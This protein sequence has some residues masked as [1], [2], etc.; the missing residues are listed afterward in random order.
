[1]KSKEILRKSK[2]TGASAL[3][4]FLALS[5]I[6]GC[7]CGG[8][9]GGSSSSSSSMDDSSSSI[10]SSSTIETPIGPCTVWG[11]PATEK[12]MQKDCFGQKNFIKLLTINKNLC[13]MKLM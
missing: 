5:V 13:I 6:A 10:D 7:S 11:A 1:M 8:G 9:V 4:L 12:I 2:K 3:S